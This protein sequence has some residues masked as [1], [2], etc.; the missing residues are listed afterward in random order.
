M[1]FA[2][3]CRQ[4]NEHVLNIADVDRFNIAYLYDLYDF[5]TI[6]RNHDLINLTDN[7]QPGE[8][9]FAVIANSKQFIGKFTEL[10]IKEI[11]HILTDQERD[12]Y[13]NACR[14]FAEYHPPELLFAARDE[15]QKRITPLNP[16]D[17]ILFVKNR[18][19]AINKHRKTKYYTFEVDEIIRPLTIGYLEA[20]ELSAEPHERWS[21]GIN[22]VCPEH[23]CYTEVC[24]KCKVKP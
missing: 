8:I 6:H 12:G 7:Q 19:H 2:L 15:I 17:E 16:I 14:T 11:K 20:L 22:K 21:N 18:Y 4:C 23:L 9:D 5:I 3:Y 1:K 24:K 10:S 13:V